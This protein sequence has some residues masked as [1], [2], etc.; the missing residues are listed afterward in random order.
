MALVALRKGHVE[1]QLLPILKALERSAV[2]QDVF[3]EL[4]L[5]TGIE[6]FHFGVAFLLVDVLQAGMSYVLLNVRLA[7]NTRM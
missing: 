3:L 2:L 6:F 5:E 7:E 4:L 1:N